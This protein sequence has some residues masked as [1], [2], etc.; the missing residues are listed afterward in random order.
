MF[1]CFPAKLI[2]ALFAVFTSSLAAQ[3]LL[4]AAAADLAPLESQ[5]TR[6]YT[7]LGGGAIRFV[8]GS[9]GMLAR[10]IENGAPYDVF[11]CA[12]EQFV[13]D[14]TA[15]KHLIPESVAAYANGRLG[16]WSARGTP[17]SLAVLG[18]SKIRLIAIAN[19]QHA[20][21][22]AAAQALLERAGLWTRLQPKIVLAENV[23]QA[24]EYA[25]TGNADVVI[26]SWTLLKNEPGAQ[27]LP[28]S[29][30]PPIRQS[31]GVVTG[32]QHEG[33]ARA[34]LSFLLSPAGQ[35]ILQAGGLFPV[36]SS[37]MPTK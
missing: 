20:P 32:T 8:F 23:R 9:S 15:Q 13:R 16:L 21:Y 31:G 3:P 18:D 6:G 14:L 25:R 36:E 27:L 11:L 24:Y 4:V 34:F 30:H 10:Q 29:G 1:E 7:S 5:L 26:T 12:N 35:S 33:Q 2:A 22:G 19:P 17:A 28:E 37:K